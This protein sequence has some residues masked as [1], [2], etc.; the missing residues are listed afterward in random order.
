MNGTGYTTTFT[1]DRTPDE[2]FAAINDVRGWW[3]GDIEGST[4]ALGDE[5]TYRHTDHHR[6]TQRITES[7]PGR[8]IVWHVVDGY[9]AFVKDTAE[10]TGTDIVFDIRPTDDGTEVRF[11]HYGLIPDIECFDDCS[12]AW[13]F[14][15]N[16]SL[17][18]VIQRPVQADRQPDLLTY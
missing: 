3:A 5:F 16:S 2:V 12:N 14:Y 8:R 9:L 1:V 6:T 11:T 18:N 10:W 17:R 7:T 15:V 13:G 4:V